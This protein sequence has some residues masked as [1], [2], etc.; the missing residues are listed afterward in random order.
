MIEEESRQCQLTTTPIGHTKLCDLPVEAVNHCSRVLSIRLERDIPQRK[1]NWID[2]YR[3]NGCKNEER[4]QRAIHPPSRSSWERNGTERIY[5][6]CLR[7]KEGSFDSC[8]FV[9]NPTTAAVRSSRPKEHLY[10]ARIGTTNPIQSNPHQTTPRGQEY[11]QDEL[12]Q[13]LGELGHGV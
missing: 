7:Y 1:I 5:R 10:R 11:N 12:P 2:R 13:T 4:S 9:E 3:D 6:Y 8:R